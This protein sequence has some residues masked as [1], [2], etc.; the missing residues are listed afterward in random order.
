MD[1]NFVEESVDLTA[2]MMLLRFICIA[3]NGF[4]DRWYTLINNQSMALDYMNKEQLRNRNTKIKDE[5]RKFTIVKFQES[6]QVSNIRYL[7]FFADEI[8]IQVA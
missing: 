4:C 3:I 7:A 5:R 1:L 6:L 2:I 8:P